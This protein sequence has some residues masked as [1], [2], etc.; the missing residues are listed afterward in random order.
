M[1]WKMMFDKLFFASGNLDGSISSNYRP[2]LMKWTAPPCQKG[3]VA[4][5]EGV[6]GG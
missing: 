5:G 4:L 2:I 3:F 6:L 1:L